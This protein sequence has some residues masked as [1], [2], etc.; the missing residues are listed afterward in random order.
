MDLHQRL[1]G[2]AGQKADDRLRRQRLAAADSFGRLEVES[3][4]QHRQAVQQ[5]SFGLA[6]QLIAPGHQRLKGAVPSRPGCAAGQ[7]ARVALQPGRELRSP[8]RRAPGRG[9]LDGQRHAVQPGAHLGDRGRVA[10]GQ[11]ERGAGRAGPGD[12]QAAGLGRGDRADRAV[13][14]QFQRRHREDE[15]AGHVQAFPAGGHDADPGALPGQHDR[16]PGGRSQDV[17]AVI[18][19]DQQLP[20]RQRPHD[21]CHRVRGILFRYSQRLGDACGDKRGIGEGGQLDQPDAVLEAVGGQRRRP[22]RQA[23]LA[24]ASRAGQRHRAGRAQ[25]VQDRG[26][27]RPASDQRAHLRGQAGVLLDP[28]FRHDYPPAGHQV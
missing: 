17:L 2:Q 28:A 3:A 21:A 18:Q 26:E 27:L 10:F 4:A 16:H 8:E 5:P 9:Q 22:Q 13:F 6:E 23:G 15:F 25:A 19:H 7:Q 11:R 14:R 1:A 20:V 24:A 12:E